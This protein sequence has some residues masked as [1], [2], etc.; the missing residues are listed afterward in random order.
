MVHA[1][2][3]P[4]APELVPVLPEVALTRAFWLIRHAD[5]TRS[6]RLDRFAEALI[7]GLRAEVERLESAPLPPP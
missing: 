1:F 4:F 2:V 7:A 3:L 5:D 6:T